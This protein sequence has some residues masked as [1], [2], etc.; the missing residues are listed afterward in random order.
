[1]YLQVKCHPSTESQT[2][3][4]RQQCDRKWC[5]C[6]DLY[7]PPL[8][9]RK[10]EGYLISW[11]RKARLKRDKVDCDVKTLSRAPLNVCYKIQ[12]AIIW[13]VICILNCTIKA[14]AITDGNSQYKHNDAHGP[15]VHRTT[16]SVTSHHFRSCGTATGSSS[17]RRE[18]Q[19]ERL[20]W[21]HLSFMNQYAR[22]TRA[23]FSNRCC[24]HFFPVRDFVPTSYLFV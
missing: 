15:T 6:G 12:L 19:E 2:Q 5:D 9:H 7:F 1:M 24:S 3:S 8:S 4:H 16:I 18:W 21:P 17:V 20:K 13:V 10:K 11:E 22:S 23:P 14:S